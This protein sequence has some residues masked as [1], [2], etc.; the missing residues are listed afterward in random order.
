[1]MGGSRAADDR[2]SQDAW[3]LVLDALRARD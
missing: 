3:P 2:A 1:V